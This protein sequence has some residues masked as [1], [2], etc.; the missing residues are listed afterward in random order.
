[1]PGVFLDLDLNTSRMKSTSRSCLASPCRAS[2]ERIFDTGLT[3]SSRI[4]AEVSEL[5]LLELED[6]MPPKPPP[7]LP[8]CEV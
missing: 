2:S 1:M 3:V 8:C 6:K 4:K 7:P 5:A